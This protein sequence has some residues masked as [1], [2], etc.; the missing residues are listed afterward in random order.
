MINCYYKTQVKSSIIHG[1]GRFTLEPIPQG[2]MVLHID[3]NIYKNENNSYI[4][5]SPKNNLD[6]D[7]NNG[8]IANRFINANEELTMNYNQWVDISHL[9][10]DI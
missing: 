2:S 4:N 7:G 6:W 1:N 8:W 5:H 9:G 10:W 3:G